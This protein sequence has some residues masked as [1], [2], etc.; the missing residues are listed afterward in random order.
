MSDNNSTLPTSPSSPDHNQ[1]SPEEP[2]SMVSSPQQP[3]VNSDD[4]QI[5]V[6][7]S[8]MASQDLVISKLGTLKEHLSTIIS[9]LPSSTSLEDYD[10]KTSKNVGSPEPAPSPGLEDPFHA[11]FRETEQLVSMISS[12]LSTSN[13]FTIISRPV[14][15]LEMTKPSRGADELTILRYRIEVSKCVLFDLEKNF[16]STTEKPPPPSEP[17]FDDTDI[18]LCWCKAKDLAQYKQNIYDLIDKSRSREDQREEEVLVYSRYARNVPD[19][20]GRISRVKARIERLKQGSVVYF[21]NKSPGKY[22]PSLPDHPSMMDADE[23]LLWCLRSNEP[24]GYKS[25]DGKEKI[26][27]PK[28]NYEQELASLIEKQKYILEQ[29]CQPRCP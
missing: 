16:S 25:A 21:A 14:T 2:W 26:W 7:C 6:L 15:N 24:G 8:Q 4:K 18:F 27:P 29:K 28:L 9:S 17:A 23:L 11:G 13:T 10:N 22:R 5:Q 12:V 19:P 20:S 1:N 3:T